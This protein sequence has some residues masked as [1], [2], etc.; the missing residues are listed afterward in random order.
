MGIR[1]CQALPVEGFFI[2]CHKNCHYPKIMIGSA[3]IKYRRLDT[4]SAGGET[5]RTRRST[6]PL[7]VLAG[8]LALLALGLHPASSAVAP[9]GDIIAP[10]HVPHTP[11]GGWHA[12]TCTTDIPQCS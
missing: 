11:A 3:T 10:Q 6:G 4:M 1:P 8:C 12:Q 7:L 2:S 9:T 5:G